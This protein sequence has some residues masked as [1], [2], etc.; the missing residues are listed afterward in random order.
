MKSGKRTILGIGVRKVAEEAGRAG[1]KIDLKLED[2]LSVPARPQAL[3][4]CLVN[5]ID[6]AVAHG[7]H[8]AV[9]ARADDG[10]VEIAVEDDGPGIPPEQYEDAFRPFSRL[11]ETRT[12][13]A[14]GVGLGLSIAREV[15]REHGG[16]VILGA[17]P[18]GGLKASLRLPLSVAA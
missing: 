10:A 9:S 14:K 1:A 8:V 18:L 11:D 3:K 13:N 15:A 4:R 7:D 12:R 17:S 2:G 5:L 16:D 6:N